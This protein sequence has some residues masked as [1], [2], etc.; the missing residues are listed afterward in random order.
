MIAPTKPDA[1]ILADGSFPTHPIPL[2]LLHNARQLICCDAA[3]FTLWQHDRR[4][5]EEKVREGRLQAIGDGDSLRALRDRIPQ[6]FLALLA[7]VLHEEN[8]QE[9]NDLTKATR[10]LCTQVLPERPNATAEGGNEQRITVAYLGTTGKREDHTL[11]NIFLLPWHQHHYPI[12]G[13]MYTDYG[14][15]TAWH[16]DACL[17]TFVHQQL[18][19]FN[20]SCTQMTSD[21]LRWQAYPFTELWQGTLNDCLGDEVR[22]HADGDYVVFQTYEAK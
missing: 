4:L 11:G 6:D 14:Y 19:I 10:L 20:L 8:E 9:H 16:G 1:V 13:T 22:I 12:T 2:H 5:V 15:F 21:G 17:K 18:S 3:L 7:P